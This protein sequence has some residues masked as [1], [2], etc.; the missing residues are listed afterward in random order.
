MTGKYECLVL[1]RQGISNIVGAEELAVLTLKVGQVRI[2]SPKLINV[3]KPQ[4][5]VA[6]GMVKHISGIGLSKHVN[7]DV[8]IITEPGLKQKIADFFKG[9]KDR[10]RD[11][12]KN[13]KEEEIEF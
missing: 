4:H 8:E 5:T 6:F 10:F 3:I 7:S 13:D 2:C 9:T 1:T 11:L 12:L